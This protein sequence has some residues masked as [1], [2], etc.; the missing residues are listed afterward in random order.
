MFD[1][2]ARG[3]CL[4]A[5]A[6]LDNLGKGVGRGRPST[7]IMLGLGEFGITVWGKSHY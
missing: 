4:V 6:R 3:P 2:D 1:N 5:M 7:N